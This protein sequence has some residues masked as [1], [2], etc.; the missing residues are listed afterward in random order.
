MVKSDTSKTKIDASYTEFKGLRKCPADLELHTVRL[1][2]AENIFSRRLTY[3]WLMFPL[4][5]PGIFRG[6]KIRALTVHWL[7]LA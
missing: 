5:T 7:T 6:F 3:F 2:L 4:Y 1:F